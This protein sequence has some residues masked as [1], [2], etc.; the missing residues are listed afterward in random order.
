MSYTERKWTAKSIQEVQENGQF[1]PDEHRV[2]LTI[3][4]ADILEEFVDHGD[5]F[6]SKQKL[7]ISQVE[8]ERTLRAAV[9]IAERLGLLTIAQGFR[10]V[11]AET[12]TLDAPACLRSEWTKTITIR[13]GKL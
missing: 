11:L 2:S 5:C 4:L 8:F 7:K 12:T 1:L 10:S 13:A 9:G 6:S 3:Q